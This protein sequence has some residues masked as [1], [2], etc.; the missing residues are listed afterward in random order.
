M[1]IEDTGFGFVRS[2]KMVVLQITNRRDCESDSR[3]MEEVVS[4]DDFCVHHD[5]NLATPLAAR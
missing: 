3:A 1:V 4:N 5:S 2:D